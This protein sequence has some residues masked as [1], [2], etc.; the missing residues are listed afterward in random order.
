MNNDINDKDNISLNSESDFKRFNK[1]K[2][3]I[4]RGVNPN[5]SVEKG[6]RGKDIDKI[7]F[8][9]GDEF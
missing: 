9:T 6:S 2:N 3:D 8:S 5:I 7:G 4:E 1:A